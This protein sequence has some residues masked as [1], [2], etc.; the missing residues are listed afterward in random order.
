MCWNFLATK[1]SKS[2]SCL[3]NS[4]VCLCVGRLVCHLSPSVPHFSHSLLSCHFFLH[5]HF[6]VVIFYILLGWPLHFFQSTLP[7]RTS[8]A[9]IPSEPLITCP[10]CASLC[11]TVAYFYW[12]VTF[13][14][15]FCVK[16]VHLILTLSFQLTSSLKQHCL[17]ASILVLFRIQLSHCYFSTAKVRISSNP[18]EMFL[19]CQFLVSSEQF[20]Q[21]VSSSLLCRALY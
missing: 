12:N 4:F 19:C 1:L 21:H 17:N 9:L 13:L 6:W 11:F 18:T 10:A 5:C 20:L 15:L 14:I 7:S 16:R 2:V 3:L 8:K